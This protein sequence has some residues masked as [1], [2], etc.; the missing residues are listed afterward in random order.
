MKKAFTSLLMSVALVI[1]TAGCKTVLPTDDSRTRSGWTNFAGAQAAF[2]KIIPHQTR[3]GD[4]KTLGFDPASNPNAKFLSYLD[5]IERFIPNSSIRKEDLPDELQ[6]CLAAR[7][8]CVAY[9]LEVK[10]T[11]N[12]RYGN[13]C[14]DVFGFV[15][16]THVTGWNFKALIVLQNDVVVYKLRSGQPEVDR[17]DKKVKPLG[18]FQELDNVLLSIP[19]SF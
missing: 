18:P 6:K 9:E 4:L 2:D 1:L 3:A 16:K 17:F 7:D 15:R 13:V 19:K 12:Q 5:V 10:S 8:G 11:H 14:A